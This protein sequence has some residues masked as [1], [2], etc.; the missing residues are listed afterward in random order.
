MLIAVGPNKLAINQYFLKIDK[1]LMLLETKD[2]TEAV[3]HLFKAHFVFHVEYDTDLQNFWI[4]LQHY[5]YK[6]A[7]KRTNK[8]IET[9]TKIENAKK[10][11][12]I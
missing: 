9:F 8:I 10:D 11:L 4:L 7:S 1:N 5:F 6:I 3:D 2:I 12:S